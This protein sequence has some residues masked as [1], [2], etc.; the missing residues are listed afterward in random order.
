MEMQSISSICNES[1]TN[2]TTDNAFMQATREQHST[3]QSLWCTEI[4]S[5]VVL[6]STEHWNVQTNSGNFD[7]GKTKN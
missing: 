4:I 5:I 3:Q 7:G 1:R 2:T 6:S